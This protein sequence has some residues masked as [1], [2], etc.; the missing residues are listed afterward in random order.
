MGFANLCRQSWYGILLV[1]EFLR[2]TDDRYLFILKKIAKIGQWL[3]QQCC[4]ESKIDD[5]FRYVVWN[6]N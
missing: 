2:R 5:K 4:Y 3:R 6:G 1:W